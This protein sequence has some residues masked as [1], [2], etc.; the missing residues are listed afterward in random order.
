[1]SKMKNGQCAHGIMG[2]AESGKSREHG[3]QNMHTLH[4]CKT[5]KAINPECA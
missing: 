3:F 4:G 2:E 1:M 5:M